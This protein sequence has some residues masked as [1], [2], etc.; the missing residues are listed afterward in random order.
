MEENR[1]CYG[2]GPEYCHELSEDIVDLL[3]SLDVFELIPENFFEG[4]DQ[5]FIDELA[6][7]GTPVIVHGIE[8]SIG[9]DGPFKQHHFDQMRKI[10]DQ[11]NLIAMSDHICMTEAGGIKIGQLTT[12][13]FTKRGLDVIC[14]QVETMSKQV[15][16]PIVLENIANQFYFPHCD[17]SETE[18]ISEMLHRT[19][20]YLLMDLHNIYAN[21]QNFSFDPYQWMSE[22]P[23]N[24]VWAIHLAGGYF[25]KD[26]FL[27]DSHSSPVPQ[28]VWEMLEWL[29]QRHLPPAVIVER[30]S[31]YPGVNE[32][33]TEVK[34][35]RKIMNAGR[36][37]NPVL[38]PRSAS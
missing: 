13:P 32:I 3:P 1:I 2:A 18:F 31:D 36:I 35:A 6:K 7:A 27:E 9:T 14:N 34:R 11:V 26:H 4:H 20:A 21:S 24:R 8:L 12:L 15:S 5:W 16:V 19:D 25:D 33:M 30:T 28:P 23:L 38:A 37:M 17:Y 29:C 22:I 10:A